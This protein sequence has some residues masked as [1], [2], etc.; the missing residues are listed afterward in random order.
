MF[1]QRNTFSKHLLKVDEP[2]YK[3]YHDSTL[4][5][6]GTKSSPLK[7]I[8]GFLPDQSGN[9]GKYLTTNG[10][11]ASWATLTI[12]S[13]IVTTSDVGTVTDTML[14][15]SIQGSKLL[16][17]T[18]TNNI[19]RQSVST[20]VIGTPGSATANVQDI[21]ATVDDQ[22]L[23]RSSG[24]LSFGQITTGGIT[25]NAVTNVK[26]R[27]SAGLSVI[28]RSASGTGNVE[29]L[30]A[31]TDG[32]VLRR[33]GT[34]LGFGEIGT[35][36]IANNAITNSKLRVSSA[37]SVIGRTQNISGEV[38]DIQASSAGQVLRRTTDNFGFGQID[39]TF[40][41]LNSINNDRLANSSITINGTSVALGGS[42]TVSGSRTQTINSSTS[43]TV[44]FNSGNFVQI[45]LISNITSLT[46]SNA[47]AGIYIFELTQ[48]STGNR[49]VTWPISI[50]WPGNVPPV[51]STAAGKID[52]ITLVFDGSNYYGT[53]ALN[54]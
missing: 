54:Y 40:I 6:D 10:V 43:L 22:V 8:G 9:T 38:V 13:G 24:T 4:F 53:Y 44:N 16:N 3:V 20:S 47:V 50:K 52:I 36:G 17:N 35:A 15:G 14:A 7:V 2:L 41:V 25:D 49:T 37:F 23:R 1:I 42:I 5:G 45:N 46:L 29:D 34:T 48:D 31:G 28:G 27:Q 30:T 32:H 19:L 12:P 51:L 11:T 33:S 21:Q 26:I 18:I 39:S